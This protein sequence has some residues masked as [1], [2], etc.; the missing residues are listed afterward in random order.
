MATRATRPQGGGDKLGALLA[1]PPDQPTAQRGLRHRR[2]EGGVIDVEILANSITLAGRPA[3]LVLA[4]DVTERLRLEEQLRQAQKMEAVGRLAGG[5]AHDFN[6]ILT[7]IIGSAELLIEDL[8][9]GHEHR[10][11][12]EEIRRGAR[13]LPAGPR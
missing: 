7:A 6:N 3:R 9:E 1:R 2:K 8:P 10:V 11:D 5:V 13:V 4:K 12:A